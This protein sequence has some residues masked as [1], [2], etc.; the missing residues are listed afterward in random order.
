LVLVSQNVGGAPKADMKFQRNIRRDGP[1]SDMKPK[2]KQT[3]AR[4]RGFAL[5]PILISCDQALSA[6]HRRTFDSEVHG[7]AIDFPKKLFLWKIEIDWFGIIVRD[8]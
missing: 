2:L 7:Q 4:G 6:R 5:V 1:R 3:P 8:G